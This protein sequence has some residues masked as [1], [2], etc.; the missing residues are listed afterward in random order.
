MINA[1]CLCYYAY[2]N[3]LGPIY[4]DNSNDCTFYK[5]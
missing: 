4:I 2:L 1:L 5:N 3:K